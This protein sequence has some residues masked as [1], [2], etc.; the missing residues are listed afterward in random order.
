MPKA[1]QLLTDNKITGFE[2]TEPADF[3]L[4]KTIR[5]DTKTIWC[6]TL[7]QSILDQ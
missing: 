4:D 7:E 5:M 6:V 2:V 3:S 1:L